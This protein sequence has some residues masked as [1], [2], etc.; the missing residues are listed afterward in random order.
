MK[1]GRWNPETEDA[2]K[3]LVGSFKKEYNLK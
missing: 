3:S 2:M 1:A